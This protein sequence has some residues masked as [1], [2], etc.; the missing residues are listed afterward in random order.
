[1]PLTKPVKLALKSWRSVFGE[2]TKVETWVKERYLTSLQKEL[3]KE[4]GPGWVQFS[5]GAF[6]IVSESADF[7][8]PRR[9]VVLK[10]GC[11]L[12]SVYTAGPLFHQNIRGTIAIARHF[13]RR[14]PIGSNTPYPRGTA[15]GCDR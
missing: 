14:Q 15:G 2:D 5:G 13:D 1:M 10:G 7:P 6:V 8:E 9:G 11:D 12:P 3:R 4:S